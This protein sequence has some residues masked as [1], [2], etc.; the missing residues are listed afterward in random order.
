MEVVRIKDDT[1]L[2]VTKPIKAHYPHSKGQLNKE[3]DAWID[4]YLSGIKNHSDRFELA[5]LPQLTT[6]LK[7]AWE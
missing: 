7:T 4:G 1:V 3:C 2:Y 6:R 5:E